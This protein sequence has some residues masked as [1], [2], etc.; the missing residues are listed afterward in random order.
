LVTSLL[1]A[2]MATDRLVRSGAERIDA[3]RDEQQ[4][5]SFFGK[6]RGKGE[7]KN[8]NSGKGSGK[9]GILGGE[10]ADDYDPASLFC[11]TGWKQFYLADVR[12]R[13]EVMAA[14]CGDSGDVVYT[15]YPGSFDMDGTNGIGVSVGVGVGV[16]VG[17]GAMKGHPSL[18]PSAAPNLTRHRSSVGNS[19]TGGGHAHANLLSP[20]R[21]AANNWRARLRMHS[22]I[23]S[24][25]L[26]F[27]LNLQSANP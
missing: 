20:V 1:Q 4:K 7:G 23:Y 10:G 12:E 11:E 22:H 15:T 18:L 16:G 9:S 19:R 24:T 6:K 27:D 3:H 5:P 25:H 14:E 21:L 2:V 13:E 17:F 26:K 8:G